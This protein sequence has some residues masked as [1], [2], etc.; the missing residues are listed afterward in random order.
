MHIIEILTFT[1][2]AL[3]GFGAPVKAYFDLLTLNSRNEKAFQ[4][5]ASRGCL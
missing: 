5:F 3:V 4:A 2:L 1:A